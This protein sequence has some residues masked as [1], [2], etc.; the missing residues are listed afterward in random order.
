MLRM[1]D[2][3]PE[4]GNPHPF[5]GRDAFRQKVFARDKQLCV[6]PQCGKPAADAH[7]ILERRLWP[8]GGYYL[9]NG[10]SVCPEHHLLAETTELSAQELREFAGIK[11]VLLPEH[12]YADEIYDKWGNPILPN[13]TRLRGELFGD[14]S[15]QKILKPVL[16]LFT[17]RVKYPRT[18]H[19]P[20]SPGVREDDRVLEN[21][22]QFENREVVIT[23][24]MD[25]ENT[26]MYR[27][28]LHAR[29]L[30]YSP[31]AS[32]TWV[33]TL[34]ARMSYEIPEGWRICGENL[35]AKHAIHYLQLPSYF[36]VF[37]VWNE[38][39]ICL[40]WDETVEW[41]QLF[42]L[43]TVPVIY[44]GPWHSALVGAEFQA[45]PGG[46]LREGYVIRKAGSFGYREFRNSVAKYVRSGHQDVHGG[47]WRHTAITPNQVVP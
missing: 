22:R 21:V 13:G 7:H 38:Q 26:T 33:K 42:G 9:D 29:S 40:N 6:V 11:K 34:H 19:L 16:S 45:E 35:Y 4:D 15:V 10:A 24:K 28:Y 2:S 23:V 39:N 44:R 1:M 3:S 36:M 46:D 47:K 18:Y 17:N 12:M 31:H 5:L 30:D 43:Q 14:E 37:S 27:D 25:G 32:R 20:W 41:A 8:D